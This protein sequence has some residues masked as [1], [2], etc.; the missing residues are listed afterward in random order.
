MIFDSPTKPRRR[1][2]R[3][4]WPILIVAAIVLAV[5]LT[6]AGERTRTELAYLDEIRNQAID[7]SRS[8]A[9]IR[10]VM[11][12]VR[13]L[14][15]DEFTTVF[16]AVDA[17]LDEGL[18]F[19][20]EGPSTDSLTPVWVMYRQ[21]LMTW[22]SGVDGL[23]EAILRAA[24]NPEDTLAV[25]L[26]AD[27]LGDLRAGDNLYADFQAEFELA[28][29]PDPVIPLVDVRLTPSDGGLASVSAS[30][31]AA[32]R[33]STNGLGLRPGLKVSQI[34]TNPKWEID[35]DGKPVVPSTDSIVFSAVIT[36]VGNVASSPGT[37]SMELINGDETIMMQRE[38]RGLEPNGQTTVIF[39]A[40]EVDAETIYE[41][42]IALEAPEL[43]DDLEDNFQRVQF[44]VN[45]S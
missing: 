43:D 2:A 11:R 41:I 18:A 34:V 39:D 29:V 13:S 44:T 5:I 3:L 33:S 36:N 30:Y 23:E 19:V 35:V 14:D 6:A 4:I 31:V 1:A 24:D 32:A 28:E 26:V 15:R 22:A 7:L 9:S 17:A 25:S 42:I 10:E 21:I 38:V 20:A 16:Q 45:P 40:V 8:G 12:Q 37:V 27:A